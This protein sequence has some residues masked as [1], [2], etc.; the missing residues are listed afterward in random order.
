MLKL[1]LILLGI[2]LLAERGFPLQCYVCEGSTAAEKGDQ[3][4]DEENPPAEYLQECQDGL[5]FCMKMSVVAA[6]NYGMKRN[7]TEYRSSHEAECYSIFEQKWCTQ[8]TTC[9]TVDGCN[10]G[11]GIS[12]N[13]VFVNTTVDQ[14]L[15]ELGE[16]WQGLVD[17]WNNLGQRAAAWWDEHK[18]YFYWSMGIVGVALVVI[19]VGIGYQKG[20]EAREKRSGI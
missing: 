17:E 12:F 13:G 20:K 11:N 10:G 15:E 9:E 18:V 1:T 6:D 19:V 3:G 2:L 5:Q 16:A 8:H 14:K 4:C 7:C